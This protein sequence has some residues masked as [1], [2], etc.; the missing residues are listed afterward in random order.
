MFLSKLSKEQKELFLQ[1]SLHAA[2]SNRILAEEEKIMIHEYCH[3]MG[4]IDCNLEIKMDLEQVIATIK[5]VCD[6]S[7]VRMMMFEVLGLLL[8]DKSYDALEQELFTMLK[9][10][11]SL[12]DELIEEMLILLKRFETLFEDICAVV[13]L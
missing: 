4:F 6:E 7:I 11:F 9:T 8:A 5:E 13:L 1:L 10:Q 3:E 2:M 12:S